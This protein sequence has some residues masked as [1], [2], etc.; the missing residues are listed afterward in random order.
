[1]DVSILQQ[2]AHCTS[3]QK[4]KKKKKINGCI[5]WRDLIFWEEVG[6]QVFFVVLSFFQQHFLWGTGR[7][8]LSLG[9]T[10]TNASI[11]KCWSWTQTSPLPHAYHPP[12]SLSLRGFRWPSHSVFSCHQNCIKD[13]PFQTV[14]EQL[15]SNSVFFLSWPPS[16]P[17]LVPVAFLSLCSHVFVCVCW[18]VCDVQGMLC[19]YIYVYILFRFMCIFVVL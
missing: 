6:F 7:L 19:L 8:F 1:M 9:E 4:K 16:P 11:P 10:L 17:S 3:P 12:L 13:S 15:I 18:C 2:Y 14:L 5:V